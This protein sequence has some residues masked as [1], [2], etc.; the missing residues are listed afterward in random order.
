RDLLQERL[1]PSLQIESA[2]L[3]AEIL[4]K[5]PSSSLG[6]WFRPEIPA[7]ASRRDTQPV[8]IRSPI[9]PV[10]PD[11]PIPADFDDLP[12]GI[13]RFSSA[14]ADIFLILAYLHNNPEALFHL[15]NNSLLNL[16]DEHEHIT[17]FLKEYCHSK[18]T[19]YLAIEQLALNE[20]PVSYA[21]LCYA[22]IVD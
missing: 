5:L 14:S 21:F 11:V 15:M 22:L 20:D 1:N 17:V 7:E 6:N 16:A 18:S 3:S 9:L 19:L 13:P 8:I 10:S 12:E 2:Q 4:Q